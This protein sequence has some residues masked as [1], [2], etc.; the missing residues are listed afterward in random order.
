MQG[1]TLVLIW[2]M[3]FFLMSI[4]SGHARNEFYG[5]SYA[6]IVGISKY[7][8]LRWKNL[9]HARSDAEMF[10]DILRKKGFEVLTLYDRNATRSAILARL[11]NNIA[12][13]LKPEDRFLFYFIGHG[14]SKQ[15]GND[16]E[17]YL[18][19]YD[20]E[21]MDDNINLIYI[22][23]TDLARQSRLMASAKHQL[24]IIDAPIAAIEKT[25]SSDIDLS[26][27]DYISLI[28]QRKSRQII[29]AGEEKKT[30]TDNKGTIYNLLTNLFVQGLEKGK[31][32][33]N[34]DG[35]ITCL[36]MWGFIMPR[37]SN[38]GQT[39]NYGTFDEHEMGEFVIS[40]PESTRKKQLE[41][42]NLEIE[43]L[44]TKT[45]A[46]PVVDIQESR[47]FIDTIPKNA[48]IRILNI[49][50]PYRY[51][52]ML[53]PGNYKIE[54]SK[55]DYK[56]VTKW[57]TIGKEDRINEKIQL[58]SMRAFSR[59]YVH[60]M[61]KNAKIRILN[62]IPRYTFGM[63]LQTG[64][65]LIEVSSPG[66]RS[67]KEW[68]TI[69]KGYDQLIEPILQ[70]LDSKT[71]DSFS[72]SQ[73]KTD[74]IDDTLLEDTD[75]QP[76]ISSPPIK[77]REKEITS[78][79][80]YLIPMEKPE[81]KTQKEPVPQEIKIKP[82]EKKSVET[83]E[84]K[85]ISSDKKLLTQKVV[86]PEKTKDLPKVTHKSISLPKPAPEKPRDLSAMTKPSPAKSS[87]SSDDQKWEEPVTGMSFIW[88]EGGCFEMGCGSW[89]GQCDIDEMPVHKVCVDGFWMGQYEVTQ[90]EWKAIMDENPSLSAYGDNYPVEKVSWNVVQTYIN[91]LQKQSDNQF[92][93]PTEAEWEYACRSGGKPHKYAGKVLDINY[94]GWF[95]GN[96]LFITHSVG[97][98]APND[99]GLY[100]MSGN[101][102]EWCQDSY[103]SNAYKKH[104]LKNPV[105]KRGNEKVVRGGDWSD[106]LP[107]LRSSDRRSYPKDLKSKDLGFRLIRIHHIK[108]GR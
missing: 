2:T 35:W 99:L 92:R 56:T 4:G 106:E 65:Y 50:P 55:P 64:K 11:E 71:K 14:Y 95:S 70:S 12:P 60:P 62:I 42:K 72:E 17:S 5:K 84:L 19:P 8:S 18:I 86:Q 58:K 45:I 67:H 25:Q 100:D 76:E 98:K 68:V 36:E 33:I 23:M 41:D 43:D 88:V 6:L 83:K 51:G 57:I 96:S 28:T 87:D 73:E 39:P 9:P 38:K 15:I 108:K 80:K 93:L 32:D 91:K 49:V 97:N 66:Y 47:L 44:T 24:F 105:I 20:K 59:L 78:K 104:S 61:P 31:A 10:S 34:G 40:S 102:S 63:A 103:Q 90:K 53:A 26:S 27:P 30:Y 94:L 7:A 54:V 22:S 79:N 89:S 37:A 74:K 101:V 82:P 46:P 3:L 48:R 81:D 13:R 1:K 107:C 85:S 29:S 16:I 21:I 77:K 75:I 52:M 69:T